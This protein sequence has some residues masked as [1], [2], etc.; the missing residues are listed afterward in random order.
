[1][2]SGLECGWDYDWNRS[3]FLQLNCRVADVDV[4]VRLYSRR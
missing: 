3:V 4:D 1:M 2:E